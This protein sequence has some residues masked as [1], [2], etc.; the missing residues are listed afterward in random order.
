VKSER[1]AEGTDADRLLPRRRKRQPMKEAP[2]ESDD[3]STAAPSS[4]P[5]GIMAS[6]AVANTAATWVRV[7]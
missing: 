1:L 3:I 4:L 6:I 2:P 5:V 7:K